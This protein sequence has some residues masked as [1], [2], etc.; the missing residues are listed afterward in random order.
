MLNMDANQFIK[1]IQA[2]TGLTYRQLA[3]LMTEKTGKKY[4]R[5]SLY[6]RVRRK[7]LKFEEA[8]IIAQIAN[9]KIGLK[10]D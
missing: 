2:Q 6:A 5:E 3:E 10:F 1:H 8:N 4:S 7:S 9:A